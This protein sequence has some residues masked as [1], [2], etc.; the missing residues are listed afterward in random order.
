MKVLKTPSVYS[1]DMFL[2]V[3]SNVIQIKLIQGDV[4]EIAALGKPN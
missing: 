1:N 3:I 2:S 4:E